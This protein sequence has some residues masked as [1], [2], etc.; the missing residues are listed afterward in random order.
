MKKE[1]MGKKTV[2][3]EDAE[4]NESFTIT[5]TI[6]KQFNKFMTPPCDLLT[7]NDMPEHLRFNP[8]VLK[9]KIKKQK[10]FIKSV[11]VI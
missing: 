6:N 9:G 3:A 5:S 4:T 11:C 2:E 1:E 8:Y 7:W 10:S